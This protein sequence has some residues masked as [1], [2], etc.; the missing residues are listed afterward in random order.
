MKGEE[1]VE[2]VLLWWTHNGD[3]DLNLGDYLD[4]G[5]EVQ[6]GDFR[7]DV[8]TMAARVFEP[9]MLREIE[10]HFE[11]KAEVER[12]QGAIHECER[13]LKRLERIAHPTKAGRA[14]RQAKRSLL[15]ADLALRKN[16]NQLAQGLGLDEV[17]AGHTA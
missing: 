12:V 10:T 17:L 1:W 16:A 4:M 13:S 14:L 9:G 8:L 7:R 3:S 5:S 11:L 15:A 2:N 6:W